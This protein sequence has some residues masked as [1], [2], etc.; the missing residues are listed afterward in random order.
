M[1]EVPCIK[2]CIRCGEVISD[3]TDPNTNWNRHIKVK[4][5]TQCKAVK[6]VEWQRTANRN[7]K[8]SKQKLQKQMDLM[9]AEIELLKAEID[10]ERN[11]HD[12]RNSRRH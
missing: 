11:K 10:K 2:R 3:L 12:N 5:C 9:Q 7:Y 6:K 4:Y 8:T 1:A